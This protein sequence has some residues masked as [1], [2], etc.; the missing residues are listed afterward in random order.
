MKTAPTAYALAQAQFDARLEQL[1]REVQ[2]LNAW[3][4][5]PTMLCL[6][7]GTGFVSAEHANT[8]ECEP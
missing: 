4:R 2:R 1:E 3:S 6:K 8:H 7:C 5:P